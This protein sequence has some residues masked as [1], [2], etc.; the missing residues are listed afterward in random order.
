[1]KPQFAI[2]GLVIACVLGFFVEPSIRD[3]WI[4]EKSPEKEISNDE[5]GSA[6]E[7]QAKPEK[8]DKPDK[9]SGGEVKPV[10]TPVWVFGL[11]TEQLP[12][13]LVLNKEA[14]FSLPG[15]AQPMVMSAGT[16][17]KP[18]RF[19]EN[20]L[21][22]ALAAGG[23][24]EATV[25]VSDTNLLDVIGDKPPADDPVAVVKPPTDVEPPVDTADPEDPEMPDD[26]PAKPVAA[27]LD[28]SQIV[29]LMK[30]QIEGG[31]LQEFKADQVKNWSA[32]EDREVDGETFQ[33]GIVDYEKET[34][35]GLTTT[36]AMA[37]IKDGK[38]VRWIS[39]KSGLYIK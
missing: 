8:P 11:T 21:V 32:G 17:V 27:T 25:P 7:E 24:M 12:A 18:L 2:L 33:T 4:T 19:N 31:A 38:I 39:P 14:E 29:D 6:G 13:K 9:P 30:S 37:L 16:E 23:P 15:A 1:M 10:P 20:L 26:P 28:E 36:Q 5:A 3:I 35:F 22:I 34:I